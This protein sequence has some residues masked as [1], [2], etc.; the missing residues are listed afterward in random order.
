[1]AVIHVTQD[2]FDT[3]VLKHS[4]IVM[5]DFYAE[6][7]GPCKATAP[8]IDELASEMKQIKFVKVDV[9]TNQD[10]ASQYSVFSIP[11]FLIVKGGK[12]VNQFAGGQSKEAFIAELNKAQ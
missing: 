12:V 10:L 3:E 5:V 1:M 6:W 2:T 4:G 7:C 11:T 8:I 9:D